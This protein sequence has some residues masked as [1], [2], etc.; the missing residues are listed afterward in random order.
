MAKRQNR[1]E[2]NAA[3]MIRSPAL[4]AIPALP[5]SSW[6]ARLWRL[7]AL[8]PTLAFLATVLAPPLNHDIAA[9]LAFA[10]RMWEGEALYRQLI[11]V[12]PPL[13]F[14]LNLL[15]VALARLTGLPDTLM[16]VLCVL[17]LC[18]LSLRLCAA[19]R[20][21]EGPA[22]AAMRRFLLPLLV[23]L[24]GYDFAQREHLMAVAAL[25]YLVLAERRIAGVAT[26][27][28]LA[29]GVLLLAGLGFALKPH[30][31]AVP[32]LVEALV[33]AARLPRLGWRAWRDPA[34]WLLGGLWALY[35]ASIPVFFPA[36]FGQVVPLVWAH[37]V[38]L[39]GAPWWQVLLTPTLGSAA[40]LAAGLCGFALAVPGGWLPRVLGLA[41]LGALA[42]ALVQ[43]K[44]WSYH[45][46]PVWLWGGMLGGVLAA[47]LVDAALPRQAGRAALPLAALACLA[48]AVFTL[49]G[50]EA[51][52]TQLG[53]AEGR[54]GRLAAWLKRE[55]HGER[56]LVLSPDIAPVYPAMN[57]A[58][59]RSVL[60]FMSTWLLQ[61]AYQSC[62][63]NGTPYREPWEMNR[64]EFF[65]YRVVAERFA[66]EAPG[67]VL[68]SRY[69]AT[70]WCGA[71]FDF[72]AYFSR[73]PL[74]A[75]AW[76]HY[77][78]KGEIDG[79][80]LFTRAD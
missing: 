73:H 36:Y 75:E 72:I 47:R 78:P 37:Y 27:R 62:P 65:V 17:G 11:D 6:R 8:L 7:A 38:D 49:R 43:H 41:L 59:A 67:A 40:V 57:Y 66:R 30:F 25:P 21:A 5:L 29:G 16:L 61:A 52:W 23:L 15:P 35:L 4:P 69:T 64:A 22:E 48:L 42:A 10:E 51:P 63:A 39:G 58:A 79:Y 55:A 3:R 80:L 56:L 70:R 14:L 26:G 2:R 71:P 68:V 13:I 34:P 24:A 31:L 18:A 77:R 53:F 28:L 1:G 9:V 19:L 45:L 46:I 32:A 44:G 60:P 50:G 12:N 74:F 20:P 76:S 54:T 33:L